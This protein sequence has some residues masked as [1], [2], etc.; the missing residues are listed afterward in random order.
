MRQLTKDWAGQMGNALLAAGWVVTTAESCTGGGVAAAI[1]AIPGSS[2]WFDCG[3]VTYSNQAKQQ[4]LG[5]PAALLEAQGAVSEP[6]VLAMAA[7]AVQRSGAHIG[8]ALS[9]IAG[10]DGGT[11]DKPVGT[12]WIAW[13]RRSDE[14]SLAHCFQFSGDREQVREQAVLAALQGIC[15]LIQ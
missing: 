15:K 10:P 7:G 8:V 5:V 1:T 3:Y 4:M 12:V 14:T 11:P 9:G 6:V 13:Y 2:A